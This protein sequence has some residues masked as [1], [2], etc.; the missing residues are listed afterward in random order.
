MKKN[1]KNLVERVVNSKTLTTVFLIKFI[2]GLI[3]GII[4]F[5]V[6]LHFVGR[7]NAISNAVMTGDMSD[8][9][10]PYLYSEAQDII[11]SVMESEEEH[12]EKV[13]ESLEKGA[14]L[15][16]RVEQSRQDYDA[17][18]DQFQSFFYGTRTN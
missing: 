12:N 6:F 17:A 2:V 10:T 14:E 1:N 13:Q 5:F 18:F 7:Y 9:P 3:I 4:A 11:G 16:E 8:A 15:E